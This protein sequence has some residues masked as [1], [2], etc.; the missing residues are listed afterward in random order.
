MAGSLGIRCLFPC[1]IVDDVIQNGSNINNNS[2]NEN[3]DNIN[4]S[5]PPSCR[6]ML[7]SPTDERANPADGILEDLLLCSIDR[8]GKGEGGEELSKKVISLDYIICLTYLLSFFKHINLSFCLFLVLSYILLGD[9][10]C[11]IGAICQ[12][13]QVLHPSQHQ[14][15]PRPYLQ[16]TEAPAILRFASRLRIL[17]LLRGVE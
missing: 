8:H 9:R 7:E 1:T 2:N 4:G 17:V 10:A 16:T 14:H 12:S 6:A 15:R 13:P 11:D 3:K 5:C